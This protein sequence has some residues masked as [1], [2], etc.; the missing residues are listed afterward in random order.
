MPQASTLGGDLRP[1]ND[2]ILIVE[3]T[4][5]IKRCSREWSIH[6]ELYWKMSIFS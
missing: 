6:L 2:A 5:N 1:I 3:K 4:C